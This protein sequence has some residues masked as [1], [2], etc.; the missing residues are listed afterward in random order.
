MKGRK[1]GLKYRK[2]TEWVDRQ[3]C[4]RMDGWM[5]EYMDRWLSWEEIDEG[6]DR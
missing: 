6:R 2:M 1:D 5:N 3:L 4:L